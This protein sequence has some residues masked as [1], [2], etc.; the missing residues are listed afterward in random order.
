M[1]SGVFKGCYSHFPRD[2]LLE[3]QGW[4]C[5][6]IESVSGLSGVFQGC[7]WECFRGVTGVLHG[8]IKRC[9]ICVL[10]VVQG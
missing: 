5:G 2:V 9:F 7:S 10:E 8:F 6:V 4:F 3:F 1:C